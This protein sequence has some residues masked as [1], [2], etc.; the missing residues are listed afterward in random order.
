MQLDVAALLLER[1]QVEGSTT[2]HR[3]QRTEHKLAFHAEASRRTVCD[4]K[5]QDTTTMPI[6]HSEQT[7]HAL[8]VGLGIPKSFREHDGMQR[9]EAHRES[10]VWIAT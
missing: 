7:R 3:Q 10:T 8:S 5:S 9:V 6:V 4:T 1:K 2:W